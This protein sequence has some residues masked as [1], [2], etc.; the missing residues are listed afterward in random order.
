MNVC[1][2]VSRY[3]LEQ[4][5]AIRPLLNDVRRV[6]RETI[7]EAEERFSWGMPTY[8]KNHNIIHFAPAKKHLGIYPGPEAVA[9]FSGVL[10]EKGYGSSKG[11]IRMPYKA[12]DLTFLKELTEYCWIVNQ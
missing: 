1:E 9:H 11:A 7:P 5:E 6:I 3:I 2:D 4:D 8:W 12:V 10:S